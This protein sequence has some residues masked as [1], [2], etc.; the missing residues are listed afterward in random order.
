MSIGKVD[1]WL[2]SPY[3]ARQNGDIRLD[4]VRFIVALP[5][6]SGANYIR[7]KF[8]SFFFWFAEGS[9]KSLLFSDLRTSIRPGGVCL[10]LMSSYN[11][12]RPPSF[13][14]S[15]VEA[16]HTAKRFSPYHLTPSKTVFV[17]LNSQRSILTAAATLHC[18]HLSCQCHPVVKF[19]SL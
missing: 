15:L 9:A 12:C 6:D 17:A 14:V 16:P 7:L 19:L 10:C 13:S 11:H 2:H 8:A 18:H 1:V 3:S 5:L 4:L